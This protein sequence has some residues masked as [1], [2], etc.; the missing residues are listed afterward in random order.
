MSELKP[1]DRAKWRMW[2]E[3]NLHGWPSAPRVAKYLGEKGFSPEDAEALIVEIAAEKRAK[4][5]KMGFWHVLGGTLLLVAELGW[6]FLQAA[7]GEK[8][9]VDI[10]S[11]VAMALGLSVAGRGIQL[12]KSASAFERPPERLARPAKRD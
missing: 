4:I 1:G 6:L 9:R 8:P 12:W 2:A 5:R 11:L 10:V 3:R 7:G